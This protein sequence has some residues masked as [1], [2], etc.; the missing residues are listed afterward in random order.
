M[1][2]D[3]HS[4]PP[5]SLSLSK[6][7]AK[8]NSRHSSCSTLDFYLFAPTL[9]LP[10]ALQN[11]N[12]EGARAAAA[13]KANSRHKAQ[14]KS[15]KEVATAQ[16]APPKSIIMLQNTSKIQ[17]KKNKKNAE[18]ARKYSKLETVTLPRPHAGNKQRAMFQNSFITIAS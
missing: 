2:G 12:K 7:L 8:F 18:K 10:L 13:A 9:F 4:P 16:R 6:A 17:Q 1:P 3:I 5:H 15:L 11:A 14:V